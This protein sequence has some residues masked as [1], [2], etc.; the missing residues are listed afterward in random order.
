MCSLDR[1]EKEETYSWSFP[2]LL[3]VLGDL[4]M[5]VGNISVENIAKNSP[6]DSSL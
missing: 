3:A 6:K 1:K 5:K 4:A 2:I